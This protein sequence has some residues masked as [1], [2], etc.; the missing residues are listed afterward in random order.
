MLTARNIQKYYGEL[1]VL[2]GV[3]V[4]IKKGEIVSIAGPSG[5]GKSTLLHILGTLDK[6]D[7]GEIFLQ[8]RKMSDLKGKALASF[9]NKH[10]GFV[11][12][13]HHLL[14]EFSALENVC[15]PG[16]IAGS[17]KKDV[18]QRALDL[19][20]DLGVGNRVENKPGELSGG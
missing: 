14:P 8:E 10:I 1:W 13:F 9:R 7:A 15:I 5:S 4:E 3:D 6:P 19:L 11:F 20:E 12:Q 17:R 2:K 16:W 18:E